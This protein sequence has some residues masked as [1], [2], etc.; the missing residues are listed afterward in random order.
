MPHRIASRR[1]APSDS[2]VN[3]RT[4]NAAKRRSNACALCPLEQLVA[5][6][7]GVDEQRVP[8]GGGRRAHRAAHADAARLP[9]Q[10]RTSLLLSPLLSCLL[11]CLL[12]STLLSSTL[13]S[14]LYSYSYVLLFSRSP[15]LLAFVPLL[16]ACACACVSTFQLRF[17]ARDRC[18][19]LCFAFMSCSCA[20]LLIHFL[21]LLLLVLS[22]F[23]SASQFLPSLW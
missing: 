13:L 2:C 15:V 6:G 14:L 23:F 16:Y 1:V 21:E 12:Y 7:V 4:R 9:A 3:R 22:S 8:R 11:S 20:L 19:I 18:S 10:T 5:G 17:L